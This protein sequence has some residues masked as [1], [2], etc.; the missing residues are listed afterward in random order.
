[1]KTR[2]LVLTGIVLFFVFT[3][4]EKDT[5]TYS[6][7]DSN[8]VNVKLINAVKRLSS[9]TD[10]R[11]AYNLLSDAEKETLWKQKLTDLLNTEALTFMQRSH[12]EKLSSFITI[13]IFEKTIKNEEAIVLFAKNWC[14][15]GLNYFTKNEIIKIAFTINN[16]G[17]NGDQLKSTSAIINSGSDD[18]DYYVEEDKGCN[19][20]L[21]SAFSCNSCSESI[22]CKP[23]NSGCGFICYYPCDGYCS[24]P[25]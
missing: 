21:T 25:M 7:A 4:C 17:F 1:M 6:K 12:I 22:S 9:T 24:A 18:P 2:F 14:L 19:C 11:L 23:S 5:N 8:A 3:G 10:Q 20:N 13:G 15:E 16:S